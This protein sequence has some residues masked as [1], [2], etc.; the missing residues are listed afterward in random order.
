M[1]GLNSK[2]CKSCQILY[3]SAMK[4]AWVAFL[5]LLLSLPGAEAKS[6]H[7]VFRVHAEANAHD[8]ASFAA[9]VVAGTSGK[10]VTIER[11]ASISENDVIAFSAYQAPD[12]TFGALLR[13]D[14]H[15]RVVLDAL[16][17]ERRGT[18]LFIFMNGRQITELQVDKRV[19]DGQIYI[20]SGL[21]P[22]DLKVMKKDWKFSEPKGRH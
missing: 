3:Q 2:R 15:G 10:Q 22:A 14:E 19:S 8:S 17:V 4:S 1:S 21:T 11:I 18:L 16:S 6:H 12:G 7:C 13:L 5:A 9:S 20:P